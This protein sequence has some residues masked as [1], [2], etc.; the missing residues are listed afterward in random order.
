M[1]CTWIPLTFHCEQM[2]TPHCKEHSLYSGWWPP[3]KSWGISYL[4]RSGEWVLVAK[5]LKLLF[6]SIHG[7]SIALR[8]G[9]PAVKFSLPSF[10]PWQIL[11][12]LLFHFG[13]CSWPSLATFPSVPMQTWI[14]LGSTQE[15]RYFCLTG[16]GHAEYS[17]LSQ[18]N[19]SKLQQSSI[20]SRH[21]ISQRSLF[22]GDWGLHLP[23]CCLLALVSSLL[24]V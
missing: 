5:P 21:G 19:K 16:S 9:A 4:Q 22:S 14:K 8:T 23:T 2:A 3:L 24:P 17:L 20:F 13:T 1:L 12:L 10:K 7:V 6:P 11:R 15:K 18:G